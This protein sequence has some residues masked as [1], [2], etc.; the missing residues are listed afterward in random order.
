MIHLHDGILCKQLDIYRNLFSKYLVGES[1]GYT[2]ALWGKILF[3]C[4]LWPIHC[5]KISEPLLC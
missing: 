2:V 1:K 5:V 4:H 3:L